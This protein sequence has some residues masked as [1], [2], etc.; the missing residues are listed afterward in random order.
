MI[1][2]NNFW[3]CE[4]PA[5]LAKVN[6]ILEPMAQGID[7]NICAVILSTQDNKQTSQ[8]NTILYTKFKWTICCH[9]Y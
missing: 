8:V 9:E 1:I 7:S 2:L 6:L 3:N 5:T 4:N